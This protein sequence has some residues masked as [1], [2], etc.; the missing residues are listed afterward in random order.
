MNADEECKTGRRN[1]QKFKKAAKIKGL[2]L[3]SK[4]NVYVV[5]ALAGPKC[6]PLADRGRVPTCGGKVS[7]GKGNCLTIVHVCVYALRERGQQ[8]H[9]RGLHDIPYDP[10]IS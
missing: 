1:I 9:I 3:N 6:V 8:G 7:T 2:N 5:D 4:R 10:K